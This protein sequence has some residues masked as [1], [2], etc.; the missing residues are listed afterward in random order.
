LVVWVVPSITVPAAV[1]IG[2]AL[3]GDIR[4]QESPPEDWL[5]GNGMLKLIVVPGLLLA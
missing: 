3:T 1:I 2:R 5:V 4:H